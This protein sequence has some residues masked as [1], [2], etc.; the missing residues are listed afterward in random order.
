MSK[1]FMASLAL[2]MSASVAAATEQPPPGCA[3]IPKGPTVCR[4]GSTVSV[5]GKTDEKGIREFIEYP[6][7]KSPHSVPQ[8][9]GRGA[10][11]LGQEVG[12]L[13]QRIFG[14]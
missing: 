11:H 13:G 8:D 4:D 14:W 9:I 1:F 5:E 10:E 3:N 7:G 2:L 12:K 6:M